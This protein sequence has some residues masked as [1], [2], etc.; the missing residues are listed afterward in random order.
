MVN[1][2]AGRRSPSSWGLPVATAH[3]W[4]K[5][6]MPVHRNDALLMLVDAGF[7]R[8]DKADGQELDTDYGQHFDNPWRTGSCKASIW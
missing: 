2:R 1:F 5:S 7:I 8:V 6:G 4:E 3:R